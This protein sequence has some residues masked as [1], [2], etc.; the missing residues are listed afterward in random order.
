MDAVAPSVAREIR[1]SDL[2]ARIVAHPIYNKIRD[3]ATLRRFMGAHVFCVWDFQSLLKALQREL[4]CVEVPW[5]PSADPEARRLIN[6]IVLDEE[7]DEAPGGRHLSHFELYLEAMDAAG[8]D[9]APIR[10]LLEDLR[11]GARLDAA[12]GRAELPPGVA[13][14]VLATFRTIASG[15]LHR[16]AASFTYGREDVIPEMF[17]RLVESLSDRAPDAWSLLR[18]YLERH[19]EHDGDRHGPMARSLVARL[20][21]DDSIRWAEAETAAREALEARLALWDAIERTLVR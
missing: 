7:S 3:E 11:T 4:T 8:G 15:G 19:I 18:F 13:D 16:I 12:L 1:V 14:F 2:T 17:G 21:G 10:D 5:I 9:V 6:E 20:C